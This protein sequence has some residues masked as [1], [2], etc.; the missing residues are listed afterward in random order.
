MNNIFILNTVY[1]DKINF[2]ST[3][4]LLGIYSNNIFFPLKS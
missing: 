4:E 3:L 2:K 1:L